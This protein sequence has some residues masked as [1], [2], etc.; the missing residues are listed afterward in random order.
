MQ[1]GIGYSSTNPQGDLGIGYPTGESQVENE[2]KAV[3]NN[4][5]AQMVAQ[6]LI[7]S[8][9]YSLFLNDLNASTGNILFGGVDTARYNGPLATLPLQEVGGS[10]SQFPITLTELSFGNVVIAKNL[11]LAIALTSGDT[12]T[13]LPNELAQAVIQEAGAYFDQISGAAFIACSQAS[14]P[15][16]LNF[17][18]S[19]ATITIPMSELVLDLFENDSDP[20]FIGGQGTLGCAFGIAP[21][22]DT[23]IQLGASF[24][25][26]AYVVFDIDN[27]EIS[28]AQTN[29]DANGT[30]VLEIGTGKESVPNAMPVVNA[31]SATAGT[32]V[33]ASTT[34]TAASGLGGNRT[35]SGV[36]RTGPLKSLGA[37]VFVA[38]G[39]FYARM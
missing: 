35:T 3:Y 22:L 18:F 34:P 9:A 31:V 13:Y 17:T 23:P 36:E 1:F 20:V 6:G 19:S 11:A 21:A 28:L 26:S 8:N 4:I 10:V 27:N 15:R 33:F 25:R 16:T 32:G 5:P 29:F 37:A 2:G 12:L 7:N 30:N 38:W 39:L 24:M 14:D